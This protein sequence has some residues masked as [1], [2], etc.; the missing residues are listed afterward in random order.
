MRAV[1]NLHWK[2]ALPGRCVFRD[3]CELN[4]QVF[5]LKEGESLSTSSCL[6]CGHLAAFHE[7]NVPNHQSAAANSS[8][9]VTAS[10]H[11]QNSSS[12]AS[13]SASSSGKFGRVMTFE[14]FKQAKTSSAYRGK[15]K[16]KPK[17]AKV[18]PEDEKVT[19]NIGLM[20]FDH[21]SM[22]LKPLWGKRLPLKIRSDATHKE[23][24]E[25]GLS[26]WKIFNKAMIEDDENYMLLYDNGNEALFMP[27]QTQEFF[28]L[29]KYREE[30]GR[31]YRR[32]VLFLCTEKNYERNYAYHV[33]GKDANYSS[34]EFGEEEE[35]SCHHNENAASP[36][37]K[38]TKVLDDKTAATH[39]SVEAG[40]SHDSTCMGETEVPLDRPGTSTSPRHA[41]Y[42]TP[43]VCLYESGPN[44]REFPQE[45][46]WEAD[47][48]TGIDEE[49]LIKAATARSLE[50]QSQSKAET[51]L[52]TLAQKYQ[53]EQAK[54]ETCTIIVLRKKIMQT[55]AMAIQKETFDFAKV[56]CIVFSGE[57]AAD[58]GGPSREFFKLLMRGV[59]QELGVFEGSSNNLVF[60]HDH[61]VISSRKPYLAGQLLSWS[62]LH[63]GPGL[64]SLSEDVYYL[65][66]DMHDDV[67]AERAALAIADDGAAEVAR[68]L[69]AVDGD[70]FLCKG[71]KFLSQEQQ[72]IFFNSHFY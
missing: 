20:N 2:M 16:S 45:F 15:S 7:Q 31:D 26:K 70:I 62:I 33:L 59:C 48:D 27:G 72:C 64:H 44:S 54:P 50:V 71:I 51:D 56:P 61:S 5:V 4:C 69:M 49:E 60:S 18:K 3:K 17:A 68:A 9:L 19:I 43:D 40:V 29:S 23:I 22:M 67:D 8:C 38:R 63:G 34:D 11:P 6:A 37:K 36:E 14:G 53:V 1:D 10:S 28:V 13:S 57:D 55:C 58:L 42:E 66:M 41:P 46:L 47:F 39:M 25:G 35:G 65:M 32:I 24:L 30:L 12:G 21:R 52:E